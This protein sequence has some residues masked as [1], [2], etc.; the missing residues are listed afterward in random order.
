MAHQRVSILYSLVT[1][2]SM[3]EGAKSKRGGFVRPC[4]CVAILA[5]G[6]GA[7]GQL[8]TPTSLREL[9]TSTLNASSI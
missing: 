4:T 9:G 1:Q 5:T 7:T 3:F 2:T 6:S 8:P